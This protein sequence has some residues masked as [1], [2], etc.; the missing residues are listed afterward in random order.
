M[1][2]KK[3][4]GARKWYAN[5]GG[6][7][8]AS[9]R[10]RTT[11]ETDDAF[12]ETEWTRS[13]LQNDVPFVVGPKGTG[14]SLLLFKKG[15]QLQQRPGTIS[16]PN[17]GFPFG[18][19]PSFGS[20]SDL[21]PGTVSAPAH[22][23]LWSKDGR[24]DIDVWT[25]LWTWALLRV[26]LVAWA[27]P[28]G[29][30][31][32]RRELAAAVR[33]GDEVL[34]SSAQHATNPF[35]VVERLVH[36]VSERSSRERVSIPASSSAADALRALS[37]YCAPV[38][39]L[40][41][42][43]DE[44]TSRDASFWVA[45]AKGAF[46]AIM[47]L[48]EL[49]GGHVHGFMSLRPEVIWELRSHESFPK[50]DQKLAWIRWSDTDL[51]N[52]LESRIKGLDPALLR[53]P[54]LRT[55]DPLRALVGKTLDVPGHARPM[56]RERDIE[57]DVMSHRYDAIESVIR[58]NSLRR[59]RDIIV[60]GNKILDRLT[61]RDSSDWR[62]VQWG[63]RDGRSVILSPYLQEVRSRWPWAEEIS[64][65]D[66]VSNYV[67]CNLLAPQDVSRARQ[68][69]RE[70]CRDFRSVDPFAILYSCGLLG[71]AVGG[72]RQRGYLEQCFEVPGHESD[73]ALP[74]SPLYM[75]API[76][77]GSNVKI[78]VVR[79]FMVAHRANIDV[80]LALLVLD[81]RRETDASRSADTVPPGMVRPGSGPPR[82]ALAPVKLLFVAA[83]GF[84]DN[85][86]P[87]R[88]E[89]DTLR[90]VL[91]QSEVSKDVT[92]IPR[93]GAK[94]FDLIQD[95]ARESPTI[96]HFS[97]HARKGGI[98]LQGNEGGVESV[99]GDVLRSIF[100]ASNDRSSEALGRTPRPQVRVAVL[101]GCNTLD[102][103]Q[104]VSSV[105]DIVVGTKA[106]I[107]EGAAQEFAALFYSLACSGISI[108]NAFDMAVSGLS[109]AHRPYSQH[110]CLLGSDSAKGQSLFSL[111][112]WQ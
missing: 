75:L 95:L 32:T 86:G 20:L 110:F 36:Y 77:Y 79:N 15:L 83:N 91:S 28:A 14:K 111:N 107:G 71:Y 60:I 8:A 51:V 29:K 18:P 19:S 47:H 42:N 80:T 55:S 108:G 100:R 39:L 54:K 46:F 38:Y 87:F 37:P 94:R 78:D 5:L 48:S 35:S 26:V 104:A 76:L 68:A 17:S 97:V 99:S 92:I 88:R 90:T 85:E 72:E 34:G 43:H 7:S 33:E 6:G 41:D 2:R 106:P 84:G 57:A 70:Q 74:L 31:S 11:G 10:A 24:P 67:C 13:F 56:V 109:D 101:A 3:R 30:A 89:L 64:I 23:F 49:S 22:S 63:I 81:Q 4:D 45:S 62:L 96:V 21:R 105:V 65:S 53:E 98:F 52:L 69:F 82:L 58:R 12:V 112:G 9:D 27:G 44:M 73:L 103:A 16:L 1:S 25:R 61:T 40:L 93:S 50:W 102:E 66:F 59:A